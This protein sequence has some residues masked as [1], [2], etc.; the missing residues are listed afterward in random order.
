[1][2]GHGTASPSLADIFERQPEGSRWTSIKDHSGS[3]PLHPSCFLLASRSR[4]QHRVRTSLRSG[5]LHRRGS[6]CDRPVLRDHSE[7]I[8]QQAAADR[9]ARVG[10]D[11]SSER[12]SQ[13][14]PRLGRA[15][16]VADHPRVRTTT[17]LIGT[18]FP[19]CTDGHRCAPGS[20]YGR[21]DSC[22]GTIG[23]RVGIVTL[24]SADP[25]PG[26]D[27]ARADRSRGCPLASRFPR[28]LI[29]PLRTHPLTFVHVLRHTPEPRS[30]RSRHT[31]RLDTVGASSTHPRDG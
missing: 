21:S 9:S 24:P 11:P 30:R 10:F 23:T 31:H 13:T 4:A 26:G 3:T 8:R 27:R 16:R 7:R 12:R 18:T 2:R 17:R 25:H 6:Q 22:V 5:R 19:G 28:G 14:W 1:M 15:S 20:W 29:G